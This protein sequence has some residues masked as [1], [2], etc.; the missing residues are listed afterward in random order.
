MLE[1]L[2]SLGQIFREAL[3]FG[4]RVMPTVA[5]VVNIR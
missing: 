1:D 2:S 4:V 3:M 5:I